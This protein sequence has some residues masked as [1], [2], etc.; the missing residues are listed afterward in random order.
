ML[1]SIYVIYV[2]NKTIIKT[3]ILRMHHDD[4]LIKHFE[5]KKI[6]SLIQKKSYWLKM[7]KNIKKYIQSCDVCQRV[8]TFQ[9]DFYD[10]LTLFFVLFCFW[11]KIL[12]NFIIKLSLNY[13]E[14]NIYD[15]IFVIIDCY[16]KM[17]FYIFAKSTWSIENFANVLFNKMFLIFLEIKKIVFNRDAL[18]TNDY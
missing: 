15:I 11:K 13:Y 12:M 10:E 5:I 18:F 9:H 4:S 3:K 6:Y 14:N 7:L 17:T 2:F 1:Y 16:S 8:K